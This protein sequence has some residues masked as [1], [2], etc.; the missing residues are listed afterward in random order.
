MPAASATAAA[1]RRVA[2]L[3]S[4]PAESADVGVRTVWPPALTSTHGGSTGTDRGQ[5][6]RTAGGSFLWCMA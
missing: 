4:R 3:L 2:V 5:C 1:V 6:G